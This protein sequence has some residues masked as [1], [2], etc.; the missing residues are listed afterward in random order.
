[1]KYYFYF[2]LKFWRQI[3]VMVL[4]DNFSELCRE[5]VSKFLLKFEK[6]PKHKKIAEVGKNS[7]YFP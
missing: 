1:M 2:K 3:L 5:F 4:L 7:T 6:F